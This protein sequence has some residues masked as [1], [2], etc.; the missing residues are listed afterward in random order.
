MKFVRAQSSAAKAKVGRPN[1]FG[2]NA[3]LHCRLKTIVRERLQA[4]ADADQRSLSD[5]VN[6]ALEQFVKAREQ[7]AQPAN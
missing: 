1:V 7:A 5:V 2:R 6:I 4:M 3:T